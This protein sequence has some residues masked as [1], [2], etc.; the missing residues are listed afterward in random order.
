QEPVFAIDDTRIDV[1]FT[2][3]YRGLDTQTEAQL[4][5][6]LLVL[7][8][9]WTEDLPLGGES[10]IGRGRMKGLSGSIEFNNQASIT[11]TSDGIAT[12]H[13]QQLNEFV[14]AITSYG[15]DGAS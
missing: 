6:L 12:E 9:L 11:I 2:F 5:L 13:R 3:R 10:N 7:K 15:K 1:V 14:Q 8:D 4:G